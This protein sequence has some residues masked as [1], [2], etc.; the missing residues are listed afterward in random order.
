MSEWQRY[1]EEER[2]SEE[3]GVGQPGGSA[4]G[5]QSA[6][7]GVGATP[8]FGSGASPAYPPP[9]YA[10]PGYAPPG[11]GPAGYGPPG[12]GQSGYPPTGAVGPGYGPWYGYPYGPAERRTNT[13]A[14]LALVFA[15]V[16]APLGLIFGIIARRQ[17]RRSG[18]EGA[19]LALAGAIIG[20]IFTAL[21]V[22]MI[23]FF[24][25]AAL[26]AVGTTAPSTNIPVS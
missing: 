7:G 16:F 12:S 2:P 4:T 26:F 5:P 1:G 13:M 15:F 10:P 21:T 18:E 20:G 25:I 11:Y 6:P 8:P 9:G 3:P 17:I 24:I 19:G 14:I 23:V 22:V